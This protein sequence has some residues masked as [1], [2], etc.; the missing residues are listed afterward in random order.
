MAGSGADIRDEASSA[1]VRLGGTLLAGVAP[2]STNCST[3][4]CL[5]ADDAAEL[6]LAHLVVH[7][8]ETWSGP[9]VCGQRWDMGSWVKWLIKSRVER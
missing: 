7:L 8:C 2:G 5:G 4:Q 9:V 1:G 3:A 6:A